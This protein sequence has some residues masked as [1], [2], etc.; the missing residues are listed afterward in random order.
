M[1]AETIQELIDLLQQVEDK[2][3]TI[4]VWDRFGYCGTG[5]TLEIEKGQEEKL[6]IIES[7]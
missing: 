5:L 2:S 3:Q 6:L 7:D 1:G 4:Y